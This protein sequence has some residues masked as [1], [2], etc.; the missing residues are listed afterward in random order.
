MNLILLLVCALAFHLTFSRWNIIK[1]CQLNTR[2]LIKTC[3]RSTYER[4]LHTQ[5]SYI[6]YNLC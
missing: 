1:T 3:K 6:F 2:R 5:T 4:Y